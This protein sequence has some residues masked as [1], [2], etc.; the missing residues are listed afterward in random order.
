MRFGLP[1]RIDVVKSSLKSGFDRRIIVN[2]DFNRYKINLFRSI[3]DILI[4]L[5]W[6][7]VDY[8][9]K[10]SRFISKIY[11][12][13]VEFEPNLPNLPTLGRFTVQFDQFSIKL[14]Y[15][16][17]DFVVRFEFGPRFRIRSSRPV[18]RTAEIDSKMLIKSRFDHD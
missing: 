7:N 5:N 15:F 6:Y 8:L 10:N 17:S 2:S 18:N 4:N 9:I 1:N 3:F 12:I 11:Q 16:R 13:L 14:D